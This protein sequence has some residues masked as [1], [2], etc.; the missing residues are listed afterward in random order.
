M[1]QEYPQPPKDIGYQPPDA[2]HRQNTMKPVFPWEG[3]RSRPSATRVFAE[4]NPPTPEQEASPLPGASWEENTGGMERYI[5]NI[6]DSESRK[7]KTAAGSSDSK[8]GTSGRRESLIISGFPAAEDRPSLPVTP[9]PRR[10]TTFWGE[11]KGDDNLPPAEG[12]PDQA[13]WVCPECGFC[14]SDPAT[15]TR[16]RP[17]P[18]HLPSTAASHL[19]SFDLAS[20]SPPKARS[21]LHRASSSEAS[22]ISGLSAFSSAT[23]VVPLEPI[24][25]PT[26]EPAVEPKQTPASPLPP[27][28]WLTAAIAEKESDAFADV[29]QKPSSDALESA[30]ALR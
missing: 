2:K 22:A 11:D 4:D 7:T 21:R 13:E 15:F 23:T 9:A 24:P 16:S 25:E 10:A 3:T 1:P 17:E 27:P 6:M 20:S 12:V 26:V 8:D 18:H 30:P 28:A 29:V 5:R 14:S 19:P